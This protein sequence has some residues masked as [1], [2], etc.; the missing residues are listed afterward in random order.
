[1]CLTIP[2]KVLNIKNNKA[3]VDIFNKKQEF[4]IELIDNIKKGDYC[5]VSNGYLIKRISKK[6]AEK[7]FKIIRS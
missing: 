2:A 7:I 1:M 6:E 5:L 3:I 4:N